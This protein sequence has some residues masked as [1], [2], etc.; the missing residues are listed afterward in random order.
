MTVIRYGQ[1]DQSDDSV[2]AIVIADT[3]EE[4]VATATQAGS[5]GIAKDQV[6][7]VVYQ[8]N[9]A[10]WTTVGHSQQALSPPML[11]SDQH[12]Y[13][14]TGLSNTTMLQLTTESYL[15]ITGLAGGFAGRE[16][17]IINKGTDPF[18]LPYE[19]SLSTAANR[20]KWSPD[21][22]GNYVLA[23]Q[24]SVALI[25]DGVDNRWREANTSSINV[26]STTETAPRSGH[27]L[28]FVSPLWSGS[29]NS[30]SIVTVQFSGEEFKEIAASGL[31]RLMTKTADETVTNSD[32]PQ[33]DNHISFEALANATYYF[34]LYTRW[35]ATNSI[36]DARVGWAGPTGF[37][38][39]WGG[40]HGSHTTL[41][42]YLGSPGALGSTPNPPLLDFTFDETPSRNGEWGAMWAGWIFISSTAGTLQMKWAQNTIDAGTLTLQKGTFMRVLRLI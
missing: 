36:M 35:T 5:L 6:N 41:T 17:T 10:V 12:D 38:M 28:S 29:D 40:A 33:N 16:I 15:L 22:T 23:P 3:Y 18:A 7:G 11:T 25:Y 34:E 26:Y 32:T 8:Y 37:T 30:D 20:F 13:N 24:M 27:N 2:I 9:G 21:L 19:S 31:S 42:T 39:A 14:P 4:L 1:T